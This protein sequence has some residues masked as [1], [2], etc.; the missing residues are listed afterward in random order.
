[1]FLTKELFEGQDS[2][3]LTENPVRQD[4]F[5]LMLE[6]QMAETPYTNAL[7][8]KVAPRKDILDYEGFV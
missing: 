5:D 4:C 3:L 6:T 7:G 2:E 8:M 1:M